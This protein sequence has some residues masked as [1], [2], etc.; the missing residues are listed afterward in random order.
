MMEKIIFVTC[1]YNAEKTIKRAIES[2][3]SQTYKNWDYFIIDNGSTDRTGKI[4]NEYAE[5]DTRIKPLS[6]KINFVWEL[7]SRFHE[8]TAD[9]DIETTYS[10]T[11]D[12]DDEYKSDFLEK[13]LLF[14]K[15]NNFDI[16][17]CGNDFIDE[18]TNKTNGVRTLTDNLIIEGEG[19]G[20][21]FPIYHQFMRT[22]WAKLIKLSVDRKC[23]LSRIASIIYGH[24]TCSMLENFRNASRIGVINE[25]FYKYYV[26]QNSTS[27]KWDD[28]RI[29]SDQILHDTAINFLIDKV[30]YV[31]SQNKEFLFA[32]YFNAIKDTLN[33]LLNVNVSIDEK[34]NGLHEIF[35]SSQTRELIDYNFFQYEE[36]NDLKSVLSKQVIEFITDKK[37]A[38]GETYMCKFAEIISAC[39]ML[40]ANFNKWSNADI[41]MLLTQAKEKTKSKS[42]GLVL[43]KMIAFVATGQPLLNG[44]KTD[45]LNYFGSIIFDILNN[46]YDIALEAI[47]AVI[48]EE[49]EVPKGLGLSLIMLALN[50]SATLEKMEYFIFFKKLQVSMLLADGKREEAKAA[51]A[52]WDEIVPND[53]DFKNFRNKINSAQIR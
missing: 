40:P 26:N 41:F 18:V 22:K 29:V 14:I 33:V 31:S 48:E 23:D 24:D 36:Y 15:E 34:L 45:F 5:K 12:A 52:D 46:N 17:V 2:V 1:A 32:V 3:M 16:A 42:F 27:Y 10:C 8:F 19:F 47:V 28:R 20:I 25:S 9:Y 51:L 39:M 11:L 53:E 37:E 4:I 43:D 30:D 38:Q 35:T 21:S 50:L 49:R 13:M 6:N 44:Y 7:G